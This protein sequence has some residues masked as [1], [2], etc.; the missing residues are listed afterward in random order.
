MILLIDIGNTLTKLALSNKDET[1]FSLL[2]TV[3]TKTNNWEQTIHKLLL[4]EKSKIQD[5][6]VCSVVPKKLTTLNK[7]IKQIFNFQAKIFTHE[8]VKFLPLKIALKEKEKTG[9]DLIALAVASYKQ[10]GNSITISLGT[11]TTYTIIHDST[12]KGVIIAPGFSGAKTSLT[13][14]A[15]QIK[16]FKVTNYQSVLG[17]NTNHA[18]SI[19]F[20]N[21]FNY[22]IDG[23]IKAIN[24]ELKAS[25]QTIITGGNFQE[26]QP[27]LQFK[28]HYQDNLVLKGLIIIYQILKKNNKLR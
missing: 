3:R 14:D 13:N 20:G 28:Y 22:M 19:G 17:I 4:T 16:S 2:E 15:A 27:F 25:L 8:L 10:F 11:A 12:L 21:G 1:D 26:L 5:I 6:I 18:L 24:N 23:T 7:I 9:S